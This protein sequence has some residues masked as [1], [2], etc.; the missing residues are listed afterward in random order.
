MVERT[1]HGEERHEDE[2]RPT[3]EAFSDKAETNEIY[4]DIESG[5]YVF[6]GE[7]GRMFLQLKIYITRVFGQPSATA[8]NVKHQ[9]S[10]K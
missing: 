10:G 7:R 8:C 9:A 1:E 4:P 5:Y 6:V 3:S 2:S